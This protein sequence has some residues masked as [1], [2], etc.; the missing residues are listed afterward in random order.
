MASMQIG[1]KILL[2]KRIPPL[3]LCLFLVY[4]VFRLARFFSAK[5]TLPRH[6][7]SFFISLLSAS[8]NTLGFLL[9]TV[10]LLVSIP[11]DCMLSPPHT[12]HLYL[13]SKKIAAHFP[14][15]ATGPS[16]HSRYFPFINARPSSIVSFSPRCIVVSLSG[17]AMNSVSRCRPLVFRFLCHQSNSSP[18]LF[19]LYPCFFFLSYNA[20]RTV[21]RPLFVYSCRIDLII[22][23]LTIQQVNQD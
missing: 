20:T 18:P 22:L 21:H 23:F 13:D 4:L 5:S 8:H 19:F 3:A 14:L 16:S 11:K 1:Y 7:F 12:L 17:L 10:F 2:E 9:R 6:S 15:Q